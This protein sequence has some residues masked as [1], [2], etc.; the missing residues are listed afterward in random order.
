MGN[1]LLFVVLTCLT[2]IAGCTS[3]ERL[4]TAPDS[5]LEGFGEYVS[6][7][8]PYR[9]KNIAADGTGR[10]ILVMYLHGG[11]SKGNDNEAQ[12]KEA[13]V[14]VISKYLADNSI[15]SIF[16]VPQCPSSGSWG[17]KMNE[18]LARLLEEYEDSCDGIYVLGGS[19]GG[20][21]TWSLANAYPEK[22]SGIMPVAGKP[23]TAS[24]GNFKAMRVCTV[25]SESDEVMKTTRIGRGDEN[26]LR[27]CQGILREHQCCR[28]QCFLHD[29]PGI[30]AMVPS[31][32]MRAVLHGR[33]SSLAVRKIT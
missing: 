17:A 21:G 7:I 1:R 8:L 27:R 2:A 18:P 12:M 15:S 33:A 30:R 22:F 31:D 26:N 6:G 13:A 24:A 14:G 3:K 16:I 32:N 20:T 19:M 11:S 4:E 5:P 23:G 10:P 25:M 28:R 9:M 29:S